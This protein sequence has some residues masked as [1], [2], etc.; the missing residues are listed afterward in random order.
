VGLWEEAKKTLRTMRCIQPNTHTA[1][2]QKTFPSPH[3]HT[4]QMLFIHTADASVLRP[5]T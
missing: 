3:T 5:F 1:R 4:S 2:A